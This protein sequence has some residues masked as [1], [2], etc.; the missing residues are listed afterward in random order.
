MQRP[1]G[2][3]DAPLQPGEE[4]GPYRLE[5][6]LGEGGMGQVFRARRHDD[7]LV[8]ALK[9]MK[10]SMTGKE[11]ARRFLREA[12]AAGTV[13]HPNLVGVL[14]TG[15]ADG[16]PYIAMRL[17]EGRSL[18]ERIQA[19]GALPIGDTVRIVH[20]IARALDA[21]HRAD[22][23]HRD[24]KPSNVMLDAETGACLTDFGL[25]RGGDYSALTRPGQ[26]LGTIDYLSPEQI[27]GEPPTPAVDIYALGCVVWECLAGKPPFADRGGMMQVC[28]AHLEDAP[29]DPCAGR[30]DAPAALGEIVNHAL[31]KAPEE[32]PPT[33]TAYATLIAAAAR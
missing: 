2:P 11:Q 8:V 20:H 28:F 21:L 22:L 14:D 18:D 1:N 31:A 4:L 25:A 7:G 29:G 17:V 9:V 6:V 32:R 19:E 23:V 16:R 24:I 33:A 15:E 26:V 13:D 12:R 30:S 3:Q 10:P 27:R 5:D